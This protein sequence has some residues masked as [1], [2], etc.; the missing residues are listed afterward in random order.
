MKYLLALALSAAPL[1]AAADTVRQA[2]LKG[3]AETRIAIDLTKGRY[4]EG[5]IEFSRI[6]LSRGG[7][8]LSVVSD[9]APER[10]LFADQTNRQDFLLWYPQG[11]RVWLK[12]SAPGNR[13]MCYRLTLKQSAAH[14]DKTVRENAA[15]QSPRLQQLQRKIARQGS[16]AEEWFWA[17]IRRQGAPLVEK[18]DGGHSLLTFLYRGA[19]HNVRLLGGPS[20]DHEWLEK[21]PGSGVWY[22]TFKVRN[23]LRL[24]YRLA[25]DIPTPDG[26]D[27]YRSRRA[28]LSVLMPDPLNRRRF[29]ESSLVDLAEPNDEAAVAP[30]GR[31][32][33]YAFYSRKLGNTRRIWI[34]QTDPQAADPVV[35]Y[36]F[37]GWQYLYETRLIPILDGLRRQN[38]LPPVA[39]VFIDNVNRRTELPANPDFADMLAEE[40]LPFVEQHTAIRHRPQH[41]V[42][43]GSS[44]GGLAAAYAAYRRPETFGN[45][46][47][48]SGS[49]WHKNDGGQKLTDQIAAQKMPPQRWFIAAGSYE[50][51][52]AGEN[53][54]DGITAGSRRLADILSA[55]RLDAVY[56]EYSGGHDYAVWQNALPDGL[57]YLF[58]RLRPLQN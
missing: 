4:I 22:K 44:Y 56:R 46:I 51:A 38:Q 6:D 20:N 41:T 30:E 17:E 52:R 57:V 27:A 9:I 34:Y 53:P 49:F 37:D 42:V 13:H 55:Q 11:S 21:L 8:S 31:L 10:K 48:L 40:L 58:G 32:K 15:P 47:P 50:T 28:L 33:N 35:L 26:A 2:C 14:Y 12:L 24:S 5:N 3:R 39:V 7:V 45:A 36:L 25:P 18:A 43:S 16:R 19:A 23:D 54:A 1:A 29:A